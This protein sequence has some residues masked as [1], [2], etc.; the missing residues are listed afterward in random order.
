MKLNLRG[1][2]VW[3][4]GASSGLGEAMAY[5]VARRG[6]RLVLSGRNVEALKRV[7]AACGPGHEILP[8]DLLDQSARAV[9]VNRALE[10]AGGAFALVIL[11]AGIS[12]RSRFEDLSPEA[13][14][15]ILELDFKAPVDLTR[16]LL[17][18]MTRNS[19]FV[20]VSSVAGLIGAPQ[21]S[22]YSSAKHALAGFGA[23]LR[24][25]LYRRGIS[26]TTAYPG[27]VRTGIDK[28]A[29]DAD[30]KSKGVEDPRI[31]KGADP[32][33][34]ARQIV[35]R[36]VA[37]KA[38]ARVAFNFESHYAIFAARYLPDLYAK[39]ASKRR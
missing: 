31:Q 19:G 29:L 38:E 26:V 6:G 20:L 36:A 1:R 13:F 3:I 25:E 2:W 18:S 35:E 12:Q 21:R 7:A 22:A 24:A 11:N 39:L 14:D 33:K 30:G 34:T 8:F 23:V 15:T 27:Y 10:L 17:P 37:G 28:A 16:R 4:T 9:A 32:A 5:D